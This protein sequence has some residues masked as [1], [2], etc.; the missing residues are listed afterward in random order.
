MRT[1][2]C[3]LHWSLDSRLTLNR[4]LKTKIIHIISFFSLF[5]YRSNF[6]SLIRDTILY[7]S[8][9]ILFYFCW[10]RLGTLVYMAES[11][12]WLVSYHLFLCNQKLLFFTLFARISSCAYFVTPCHIAW[13]INNG[14]KVLFLHLA[15]MPHYLCLHK[16]NGWC[17]GS[18]SYFSGRARIFFSIGKNRKIAL[19]DCLLYLCGCRQHSNRN[20]YFLT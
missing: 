7:I 5:H 9:Y 18:F 10:I 15:K 13:K 16:P 11:F 6:F 4:K 1:I 20:I 3:N 17:H 8:L 2:L 19:G 12:V 14:T